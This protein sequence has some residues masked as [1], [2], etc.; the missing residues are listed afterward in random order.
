MWLKGRTS[1]AALLFTAVLQA[2]VSVLTWHNDNAR[3]GQNLAETI[4][5]PLNTSKTAVFG[6]L[7]VIAVDGKVDAQ[8]LY[9]PSLTM[10]LQGTHN[11]LY[12]MTE[13]DS[14][15]AFDADTGSQLWHA[16]VSLAGETP[17]DDRGCS[18]VTPIIGITSTPVIDLQSGPHG[19]IYLVAMSKDA[20]GNYYQRLHALDLTTGTEEFGGPKLITAT[21]PGTGTEGS[22]GT[23]VFDPKQHKER[24]ALLL[25]NGVLYTSWSSH[26]DD[27]PYTGW[28]MGYSESTLAQVSIINLTPNGSEG[29]LWGAGAGPA[30][31]ASGN[32]YVMIANGTFDTTLNGSG[33][34]SSSDYGNAFVKIVPQNGALS[35]ADYF[36]MYNTVSESD[37]DEDLGSGGLLLLPAVTD[38]Q[39]HVRDLLV[40]AGKDDN[41]YVVDRD[42]MGK[43]NA[44]RNLNY[45]DLAGAIG[46]VWSSPAWFNGT[47]YYG[48]VSDYVKAFAFNNGLFGANPTSQSP[49]A[50]AYPGATP[51]ISANG[52]VNAI[53]WAAE[54]T[55]PATLHAYD[56]TNLGTELYNSNMAANRRDNF[57][58]GN[59]FIVP[60]IANGKVYVGTTAG[61]G[62]FGLFCSGTLSPDAQVAE[63]GGSGTV[64]VTASAG[65][66]WTAQSNA[67]FV[68]VTGS[69]KGTGSG[70]VS[71]TVAPN[72]GLPRTATLSIA[73]ETFTITQNGALPAISSLNP[74]SAASAG[75]A[76]LLTVNGMNFVSGAVVMWNAT[77]LSTTFVSMTQ[78]TAAVPA[79]LIGSPGMA[80]VTAADPG[81]ATSN[82]VG[83]P[84]LSGPAAV[85]ASPGGGSGTTQSFTFTLS[86]SAGWQ[87][88]AVVDVL[89]NRFLNGRQ[90]CYLAFVPSGAGAGLVY[91]VDDA[92]DAGGP[93]AGSVELPGTGSAS[94]SQCTVNGTGSSVTGSGTTITLT[95]NIG[96]SASFGGNKVIYT[97]ARDAGIGNSG[98]QALGTWGV[99]GG[100]GTTIRALDVI[101]MSGSGA[102]QSFTFTF[103]DSFGWQ[104]LGIMDVLIN[105]FLNGRNAC[106]VAYVAQ[107]STLY[108]VDDAGDGGGPFAGTVVLPGSGSASNSQCTVNG[109]GSSVSGS[110][111]TLTL[112]LNVSFTGSFAGNQIFYTAARN[113]SGTEN[114]G[115]QALGAWAVP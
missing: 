87:S 3:T 97:A 6:K 79:G 9:V 52:T 89:I 53:V 28:V 1:F 113:S 17:S 66:N 76:F 95:L 92:G 60:T 71:Y 15:Y 49:T 68:S 70:S 37:A 30:V 72:T 109:A 48:A 112:T 77:A 58:T 40:G 74:S 80:T 44:T 7:F 39:G 64:T 65:C 2:Q 99:P 81:S 75:E 10:A 94:N 22:H 27:G 26:C 114:S 111:D 12:V 115:W 5:T 98:W 33:F 110:D 59:K 90:A 29:A 18:Q 36:T 45:Q 88:L 107:S 19:T 4:L 20:S 56:A 42:N 78:L 11:V 32:I 16:T 51:S 105:N 23:Q 61:V 38:A 82:G 8:P 101:P 14:A 85:S 106:Y 104:D 35:V 102:S 24:A 86:D 31:D 103:T 69:N 108:L 100:A 91:L 67:G 83:F 93:F 47:L 57:G 96:F 13:N 54:N 34:P 84:I 41:I 50:F 43:F 73:G 55:D 46:G 63:G 21:W 25:A 62:V